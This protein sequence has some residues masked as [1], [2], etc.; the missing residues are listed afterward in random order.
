MG[1]FQLFGMLLDLLDAWAMTV[2]L[3]SFWHVWIRSPSTDKTRTGMHPSSGQPDIDRFLREA[4]RRG[5]KPIL[6]A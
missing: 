3:V 2:A 1:G 4:R 6:R 5:A